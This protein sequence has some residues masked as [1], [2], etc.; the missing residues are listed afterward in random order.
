MASLIGQR[1]LRAIAVMIIAAAHVGCSGEAMGPLHIAAMRGDAEVVKSW[2]AQKHNLDATYDEPSKGLEGNYAR[3]QGVTALMVAA[4]AGRF[5]IV[6]LLVEG[7]A[8]LYPESHWPGGESP[9]TAFDY[10]VEAGRFET[11]TYLWAKSDRVRFASR[12]D[13]HIAGN[14]SRTCDEKSGGDPRTSLALF[15]ISIAPDPALGK[16]IGQAACYSQRPL[17][18]LAYLDKHAVRFPKNTL[19]CTVSKTQSNQTLEQR[20]AVASFFLDHG[21][22]PD[23]PG[24]GFTPLMG[25]ALAQETEMVKL[26]L[27]RGANPNVQNQSGLT[28]IGV[29]ANSCVYGGSEAQ[30]EAR[31]KAQLAVTE[32]LAN[33]AWDDLAAL[34]GPDVLTA[35]RRRLGY[36]AGKGAGAVVGAL[37]ALVQQVPDVVAVVEEVESSGAAAVARIRQR[38]T[39]ADGAV[40]EWVWLFVLSLATDGRFA[41]LEWFD[42]EDESQ[43]RARVAELSRG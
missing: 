22:D 12:L 10:A 32:H 14:C 20:I 38:G 21:A 30:V 35:D 41:H 26:L 25:A 39:S 43:A 28:A 1:V 3:A 6:K 19:H 18:L 13:Q 36:P 5:V 33:R 4:R 16:G 31:Q 42:P 8:N 15:L 29:A 37:Q 40:A 9:H 7:G 27:A 34:A 11:V 24:F 23:D 2:I 17:E